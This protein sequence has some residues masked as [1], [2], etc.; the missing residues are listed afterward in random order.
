MKP[1]SHPIHSLILTVGLL[2]AVD[3]LSGRLFTD[4]EG[5]QIEAEIVDI[6]ESDTGIMMVELKR[7]DRR[8]FRIEVNRFSRKDQDFIRGKW[9]KQQA[10]ETLLHKDARI[11]I[12]L[13][14]NRKTNTNEAFYGN[15]Y[16]DKTVI[17]SPEVVIENEELSQD[18]KGNKV[19]IVIVAKDKGN[20]SQYLIASATD[21]EMDLPSRLK[22]SA[23][24]DSFGLRE[25]E[26]RSGSYHYNYGYDKDDY[27]V[28][29]RN[30]KGE[31]THS[32]A[33]SNKLLE[34]LETALKCKSGEVYTEGLESKLNASPNTYYIK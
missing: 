23:R 1:L 22:V 19:R 31:I 30:R 2:L 33:S 18:F 4:I 12:N 32:R 11:S 5:R 13:K 17:Y 15:Q 6:Y 8:H 26:Y 16:T 3:S 28:V 14:L 29:I 27:V 7:S 25:R 21:V 9:E 20:N 34:N 10:A 24:G